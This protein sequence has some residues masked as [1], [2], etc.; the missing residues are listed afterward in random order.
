MSKKVKAIIIS[1]CSVL[2]LTVVVLIL[3]E[4]AGMNKIVIRNNSGKD[5]TS[6]N[7]YFVDY[8]DG[9]FIADVF[10]GEILNGQTISQKTE[11]FDFG[12]AY[13]ECFF[14]VEFADGEY[15]EDSDGEFYGKFPGK[16][17]LDFHKDEDDEIVLDT[18]AS[19]GL[20]GSKLVGMD[21]RLYIDDDYE[22][23]LDE[24][25][26]IYLDELEDAD[27]EADDIDFYTDED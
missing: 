10:E 26:V 19:T 14:E 18:N 24:D 27:F 16:I 8:E 17:E 7:V 12:K 4:S 9:S 23:V 25:S 22:D 1:I 21:S 11:T 6:L 3:I 20:F 13:A 15:Y 2:F 5:I